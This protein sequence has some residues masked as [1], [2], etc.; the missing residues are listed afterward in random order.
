[1]CFF[2]INNLSVCLRNSERKKKKEQ[3]K[4]M[5]QELIEETMTDIG[6]FL[7]DFALSYTITLVNVKVEATIADAINGVV[8]QSEGSAN[9]EKSLDDKDSKAKP[10]AAG[11]MLVSYK[12]G[13]GPDNVEHRYY[14]LAAWSIKPKDS[15][16]TNVT[17]RHRQLLS[18]F[19]SMKKRVPEVASVAYPQKKMFGKRDYTFYSQRF[20][21]MQ[22]YYDTVSRNPKVSLDDEWLK[23]FKLKA[24]P[25]AALR[26]QVFTKTLESI[27]TKNSIDWEYSF[28]YAQRMGLESSQADLLKIVAI[29]KVG[30]D[31]A[32]RVYEKVVEVTPGF[33]PA[34]VKNKMAN[35]AE[36]KLFVAIGTTVETGWTGIEQGFNKVAD[37]LGTVMDKA[38]DPL[39]SMFSKV[40][41]PCKDFVAS[42]LNS[43]SEEKGDEMDEAL[44]SVRAARF[45]PLKDALAALA[46]GASAADTCRKTMARVEDL[47]CTWKYVTYLQYPSGNPVFE[48][49]PPIENIVEKHNRLAVAMLDVVYVMGR[50]LCRAFEPLCEYADK[51]AND[52]DEKKHE[53]EVAKAVWNGGKRLALDFMSLPYTTWRACWWCGNDVT[54]QVLTFCKET[55]NLQADLLGTV[56]STWKPSS[57]A[58]A[59][60]KFHDALRVALDNFI[61]D[62]TF[63]LASIIRDGSIQ[64]VADLFVEMFGET[65]NEIAGVLNDLVSQLPSP[66]SDLKPGDIIIAIFKNLVK[67]TSN[68]AIKRWASATERFIANPDAGTP[69]SWKEELAAKFRTSPPRIRNDNDDNSKPE[70]SEEDK[71][72]KAAKGAKK[73]DKKD[74]KKTIR[75]KKKKEKEDKEDSDKDKKEDSDK[76]DEDKGEEAGGDEAG[77]DAGEAGGDDAGASAGGSDE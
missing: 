71:K 5:A 43:M 1:L 2:V 54:Q 38:M 58:D 8:P 48:W 74:E 6:V 39:K 35:S 9:E 70:V 55:V 16:I 29:E 36:G 53:E 23:F 67:V 40:M 14:D 17:F 76:K 30:R 20:G 32:H 47:N 51:A 59:K 73:D 50:G 37:S 56:A 15:V 46:S 22:K 69:P 57:K 72:K 66:L 61:G 11:V 7:K 21:G 62:R 4:K 19:N 3:R 77:G 28:G 13:A 34:S 12:Q 25:A 64:L 44:K 65:V 52:F 18:L 41:G 33:I 42:K 24:D 63:V 26:I 45:P 60:A 10:I 68:A 75:K 27:C 49:F 31:A